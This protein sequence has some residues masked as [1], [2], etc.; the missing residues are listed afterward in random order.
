MQ[1]R[2]AITALALLAA[3]QACAQSVEMSTPPKQTVFEA[4]V[5]VGAFLS[6]DRGRT[7]PEIHDLH[8]ALLGASVRMRT[9]AH[10]RF[11]LEMAS[12]YGVTE[13]TFLRISDWPMGEP[14]V[15][16]FRKQTADAGIQF[17]LHPGRDGQAVR[18]FVGAGIGAAWNQFISEDRALNA[19]LNNPFED[20]I[21]PF[22]QVEQGLTWQLSGSWSLSQSL[23]YRYETYTSLNVIGLRFSIVRSL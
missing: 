5:R 17:Q 8:G 11:G 13:R 12:H 15:A 2:L 16:A 7:H 21:E 4:G 1:L 20:D 14:R 9:G 18:P 6:T 3:S 23:F 10:R 22:A 19:A